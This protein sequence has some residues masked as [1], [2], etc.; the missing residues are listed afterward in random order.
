MA[1]PFHIKKILEEKTITGL[2][3]SRGIFPERKHQDRWVYKCPIHKGDNDPS[4]VVYLAVDNPPQNYYCFGCH[5]GTNVINL[6]RDLDEISLKK[7]VS[8]LLEGMDI[9][10]EDVFNSVIE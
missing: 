3:E 9:K 10:D 4:F 8:Q 6:L 5:S 7:A 1:V 2:L